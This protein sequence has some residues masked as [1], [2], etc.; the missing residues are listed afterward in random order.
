MTRLLA[1][2]AAL[3]LLLVAPAARAQS[4][5]ANVDSLL[6]ADRAF[7]AAAARAATPVEAVGA[8]FDTEVVLPAGPTLTAGRD[9][10]L[11]VLRA[12]PTWQSGTVS[13]RP[14][15]G[16]VSADGTQGFT[17]GYLTVTAGPP[18]RRERKYLAYWVRRA[19]GWRVVAWRQ[20]PREAGAPTEGM[21]APA[22]PAFAAA[23][24]ADAAAV[25]RHQASLAAAERAF[26]DRAQQVGLRAAFR[27]YGRPDAVNLGTP[28]A[29][30]IQGADTVA[31][32]LTDNGATSPLNWSTERAIVASSGDLGVSLGLIRRNQ[33]PTDGSPASFAFFTIWKRDTPDGPWRYI[34]E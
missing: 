25:Q 3:I 30:F 4:A 12:I 20:S 33:P 7:A 14:V 11:A 32:G 19:E 1:P 5:Q 17:Y 29:A 9:A 10:A 22:L 6:A 13:W 16:G 34:A 24:N 21:Q 28:G 31:G 8:M 2:L 27:E 18:E 23:P 26:S 15:R